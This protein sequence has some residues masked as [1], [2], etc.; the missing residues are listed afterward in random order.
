MPDFL[1]F[2]CLPVRFLISQ[3][4]RSYEQFVLFIF[5]RCVSAIY[6]Y[7]LRS[8]VWIVELNKKYFMELPK[9]EIRIIWSG[10]INTISVCFKIS[11]VNG[12]TIALAHSWTLYSRVCYAKPVKYLISY[13]SIQSSPQGLLLHPAAWNTVEVYVTSNVLK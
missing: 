1:H 5:L 4:L 10:I 13:V 8:L 3:L 6:L 7:S 12:S 2:I 9:R 11:M